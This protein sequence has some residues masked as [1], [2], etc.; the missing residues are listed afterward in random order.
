[1]DQYFKDKIDNKV[2][3]TVGSCADCL[4]RECYVV[5]GYVRDIFLHRHSKDM[6]FVTVGSGIEVAK[7][8]ASAL[9]PGTHLSV[10]R[11]YGTAQ[12]KRGDLELEFVG[13]RKESYTPDSRNPMVESGSLDDDLSRRD[14]TIN[15][16]AICVNSQRFGE[17][18]DKFNGLSDMQAQIIRTPLDPDI[19]FSD[20]PLR[21]MRAVRF[22]TQLGFTIH[23]DTLE[24]IHR[25]S[26][27]ITIITR[28]R[29]MDE[30]M[31][32]MRSAKPSVGWRLL[33]DTGLLKHIFPELNAL[34]GVETVNGRS[35]K[36]NFQHTLEVLDKVAAGSEDVWLR[37]AA[38]LHDIAKPV[39]KRWDDKIGWTF[40]NHNFIGAKMVPKIFKA[41][42]FPL[43]D[44]M[45]Y[46][47]K[48]V[49]L[50]M[51]PIALVE[52]GVTDSA[53]RR[54]LHDAGE[55]LEDL[56]TLCRADITSKNPEKVRRHLANFDHV[57]EKMTEL[58]ARD[59][60]RN[61]QPPVR[62]E[63]IM[64]VFGLKPCREVGVIKDAIKDAI[65]D[66][67]IP[68]ERE[69]GWQFMLEKAK[70]LGLEPCTT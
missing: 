10:F 20:D 56:M 17:L 26:G 29:I 19:T 12:V 1:M 6:D 18:V 53:V 48:M 59:H 55:D 64:A 63:E 36:D 62:G 38:L 13:A 50:H 70:E 57:R 68:N 32:I 3:R 34:R 41:M 8:V 14:F 2:M 11:T 66:G 47:S 69:A 4:G 28:E 52:D 45:K 39:T 30:L 5:G 60:V 58:E 25:N 7:S 46:V 33:A 22:A 61:F 67:V 21:M 42:K 23:P 40:H 24:A 15:A 49:E 44:H 37:W 65:L 31:K 35:H 51:R 43:N 9:G 54:L 27:R 16:L